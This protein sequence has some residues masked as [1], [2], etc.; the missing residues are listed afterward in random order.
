MENV[1][2]GE[3]EAM[4]SAPPPGTEN[5]ECAGIG[6]AQTNQPEVEART[7]PEN[8]GAH[9]E[10]QK[11]SRPDSAESESSQPRPSDPEQSSPT[12]PGPSSKTEPDGKIK[13]GFRFV[14]GMLL[15]SPLAAGESFDVYTA[16]VEELYKAVKPQGIFDYVRLADIGHALWEEKRYRQQLVALPKATRFKALVALVLQ[17]SPNYQLKASE[18]ALDYYG[19]DEER[20]ARAE[21]LLRRYGITDDA[22]TA[23]A[24]EM[25]TQTIGALERMVGHR[26]NVRNRAIKEVQRD[27]RKAEKKRTKSKRED[28]AGGATH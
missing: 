11:P 3:T 12:G 16:L 4:R 9:S 10:R 28:G 6:T 15:L 25:H 7:D 27:Q 8:A 22:I 20:Y 23:Q 14:A 17:F 18:I 24:H 2:S 5:P 21:R 19:A 13:G 26:Q 1:T